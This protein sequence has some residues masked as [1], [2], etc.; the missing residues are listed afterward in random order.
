MFGEQYA[1][2]FSL[3]IIWGICI[4]G[5][6]SLYKTIKKEGKK[7]LL[8]NIAGKKVKNKDGLYLG[9]LRRLSF[10]EKTGDISRIFVEPSKNVDIEHFNFDDTGNLIFPFNS[11]KLI[12]DDVI[13][14]K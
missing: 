9:Y 14:E 12:D 13:I 7:S 8:S 11:V 1:D 3:V 4:L 2:L 10:D 6:F 5:A